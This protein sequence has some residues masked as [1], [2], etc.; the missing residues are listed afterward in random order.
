MRKLRWTLVVL[1]LFFCCAWRG[2]TLRQLG[3]IRSAAMKGG[4]VLEHPLVDSTPLAPFAG[5]LG[6]LFLVV[7]N[8]AEKRIKQKG[9]VVKVAEDTR[10]VLSKIS[11]S[12]KYVVAT[13]VSAIIVAV[14]N[15]YDVDIA[16]ATVT[17]IVAA[18]FGL[19]VVMNGVE[20]AAEKLKS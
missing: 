18:L 16:P 20:D 17:K 10:N 1:L 19:A 13:L 6:G 15:W 5:L 11:G 7:R 4:E 9:G 12:R 14:V 3:L 8:I 2:C